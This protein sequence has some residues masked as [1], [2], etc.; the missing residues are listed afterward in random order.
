MSIH[1]AE[2]SMWLE[3]VNYLLQRGTWWI[4]LSDLEQEGL[5]KWD[6]ASP[7]N[8]E[9]W[10]MDEPNN[11]GGDPSCEAAGCGEDCVVISWSSWNDL[12]CR[13]SEGYICGL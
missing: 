2:Q 10:G 12:R 6:D 7:L 1:S 13:D 3:Y 4:G 9:L 11:L 5:F 8:F